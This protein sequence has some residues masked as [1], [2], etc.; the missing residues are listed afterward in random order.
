M[1][2][3]LEIT[4]LYYFPDIFET[5]TPWGKNVYPNVMLYF[6]FVSS[7]IPVNKIEKEYIIHFFL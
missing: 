6:D 5:D 7:Y 3:R 1:V 4:E 2:V